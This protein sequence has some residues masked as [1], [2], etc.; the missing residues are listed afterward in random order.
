MKHT[1]EKAIAIM[2]VLCML[3]V[4]LTPTVVVAESR[5]PMY[6][7]FQ[8]HGTCRCSY[9]GGSG[10]C[11][12]GAGYETCVICDGSGVCNICDGSGETGVD[13]ATFNVDSYGAQFFGSS[14]YGVYTPYNGSCHY[15]VSSF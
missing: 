5:A 11:N 13:P 9:C 10:R 4:L 8:C 14:W 3:T 7:C 6:P 12:Y 1:M 15:G 2:S